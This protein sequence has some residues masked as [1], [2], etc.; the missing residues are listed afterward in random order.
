MAAIPT[1]PATRL[2]S[3]PRRRARHL[4]DTFTYTT[5]DGHGGTTSTT[6]TITLDRPPTVVADAGTAVESSSGTGNVLT[7]DSDRDGDTLVVSAVNGSGAGVGNSV[8]G[9]YGHITISSTGAYTY[10]ADNTSAID[11]AASGLAP[12]RHRSPTRPATAMAATTTATITITAG[13]RAPTV[14]NDSNSDVESATK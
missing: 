9:T 7:N 8:A 11:S 6:V 14:V 13:P 10:N 1:T 3:I 5:S 2:R 4:T 12:D